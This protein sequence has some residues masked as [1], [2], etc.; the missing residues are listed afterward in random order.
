MTVVIRMKRGGRRNRPHYRITVAD[1]RSPRDGRFI[2]SIGQYDPMASRPDL[3]LSLDVERAKYWVTQ[4]AQPSDTVRSIFK[5][6][7]VL[8][9]LPARKKRD[10]SGRKSKTQTKAR[11]TA[12]KETR[13]ARRKRS[14]EAV[15]AKRK[16]AAAAP[17]AES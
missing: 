10:R 14:P 12:A 11:R 2:E 16:A 1:S 13:V 6:N 3:L 9:V 15:R 8:E 7:G 4:G 5:R 17:K